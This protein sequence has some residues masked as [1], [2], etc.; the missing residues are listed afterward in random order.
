MKMKDKR[1]V[2]ILLLG[3]VAVALLLVVC[4]IFLVQPA[5]NGLVVKG[6]NQGVEDVVLTIAQQAVTCQ[7]P[8]ALPI[9]ENQTINLVAL[10]CYQETSQ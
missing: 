3:I 8:V 9:G 10:E 7:Q 4:Y 2:L 5:L 1:D 6:Y